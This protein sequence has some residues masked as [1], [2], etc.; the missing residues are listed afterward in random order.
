MSHMNGTTA[1]DEVMATTPFVAPSDVRQGVQRSA[2]DEQ[3][4]S[5]QG[6]QARQ[7]APR[8]PVPDQRQPAR[9]LPPGV[10][11][12][13]P[14]ADRTRRET[15]QAGPA[16]QGRR[17]QQGLPDVQAAHT[18]ATVFVE[19]G[20]G[21]FSRKALLDGR[22]YFLVLCGIIGLIISLNSTR[23]AF[24][25]GYQ[26]IAQTPAGLGWGLVGVLVGGWITYIQIQNSDQTD[27]QSV[28]WYNI[29]LIVDATITYWW[30]IGGVTSILNHIGDDAPVMIAI[31]IGLE[32]GL[33]ITWGI[34]RLIKYRW[35]HFLEDGRSVPTPLFRPIFFISLTVGLLLAYAVTEISLSD[36]HAQVAV[37]A[38]GIC[39]SLSLFSAWIPEQALWGNRLERSRS[40]V[41]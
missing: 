2:P 22:P 32:L 11:Q 26:W 39:A 17:W 25:A 24:Q 41:P 33:V 38:F 36:V 8:R 35:S 18:N 9:V 28:V 31:I 34:C 37:A 21:F 12:A 10:S 29:S 40:K 20:T 16:S 3:V 14:A 19:D 30:A 15:A 4:H 27:N 6:A 5:S 13:S 7:E 23:Q 1:P